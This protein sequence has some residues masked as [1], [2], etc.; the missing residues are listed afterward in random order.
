[1]KNGTINDVIYGFISNSEDYTQTPNRSLYRDGEVLY[2][3]G[4]HFPMA[5]RVGW[6]YLIN[7][8][9][10]SNT[11]SRH[12]RALF[13]SINEI[14]RVE[15]PF[16]ALNVAVCGEHYIFYKGYGFS[17]T[18]IARRMNILD[19]EGDTW[20]ETGRFNKQGEEIKTHVLGACLFTLMKDNSELDY[21]LSSLDETGKDGRLYFLTKLA[22]PVNT[23]S[24]ALESLKPESVK[25]AEKEGKRV[26]R[27]GEWFFIEAPELKVPKTEIEKHYVLGGEGKGHHSVTEGAV[28]DGVTYARGVVRHSFG[29]H[30]NIRL[31][32][33]GEK[34]MWFSVHHNVQVESF[35]AIGNVD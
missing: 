4:H 30:K 12:Q 14:E 17:A 34:R 20:I 13:N 18:D 1:M 23:V 6:R 25:N 28:I 27:Q 21:Y 15:I 22:K 29:E 11:T 31:Y 24:E 19:L 35:G 5:V 9:K 33:A 10:Y 7:G 3:Y 2:S 32:E 16:S 8:D 26:Y